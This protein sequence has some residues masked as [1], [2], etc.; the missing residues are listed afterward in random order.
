MAERRMFAKSV[1][2]S[3][4]FLDMPLSTQCL[5]F[6]LAMRADDDGF[7]NCTKKVVRLLGAS[8]DDLKLL[9]A[10]QF[11]LPFQSGVIVI[12]HWRVHNYL[13]A[14]RY[15]PT[16]CQHERAMLDV[17]NN[18]AYCLTSQPDT[19]GIP[20]GNQRLTQEREMKERERKFPPF[21]PE[22]ELTG[23]EQDV[24]RDAEEEQV[25]SSPT[26][27]RAARHSRRQDPALSAAFDRFWEAYPRHQGKEAARKALEKLKPDA[28]LLEIMLSALERQRASDQWRRD[29]GQFIP[30]PATWLNGRRWEDE[31]AAPTEGKAQSYP[32]IPQ[33]ILL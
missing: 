24:P 18:G 6:H 21:P 29:G 33:R 9:A 17:E 7:V 28:A 25:P 30:H 5:Y 13:R 22:G 11:V 19:A 16:E 31:E 3:D 10:K 20:G 1:I 2:D 4:L 15:K 32:A 14:D 27:R 12:R 8:D 23:F 26:S